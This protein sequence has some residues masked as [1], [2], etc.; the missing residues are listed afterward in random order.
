MNTQ[1]RRRDVF[2]RNFD[3]GK[4]PFSISKPKPWRNDT[5]VAARANKAAEMPAD[6]NDTDLEM[7]NSPKMAGRIKSPKQRMKA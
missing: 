5:E 2:V 1:M 6:P 4:R 3:S 7:K